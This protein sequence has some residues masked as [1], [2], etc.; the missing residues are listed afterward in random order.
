AIDDSVAGSIIDG[1]TR[2]IFP[3]TMETR[4]RSIRQYIRLAVM[5]NVTAYH[6]LQRARGRSFTRDEILQIKALELT[7]KKPWL[8][9]GAGT[10]VNPR[11]AQIVRLLNLPH[12][13]ALLDAD[14]TIISGGFDWYKNLRALWEL[15]QAR[16]FSYCA[17]V[18]DLIP[19]RCPHFVSPG[20]DKLLTDYFGEL[21][22]LADR[23]MCISQATRQEWLRHVHD[24][25]GEPAATSTFPLG[26]DL[27]FRI[28]DASVD[29]PAALNGKHF[30][31]YV[32][33][34]EP[35]KNHYMLYW[36]WE[37]CI[38]TKQLDP[39]RHRLV[40]V[41]RQGWAVGDLLHEIRTNPLTRDTI[42]ILHD[43]GDQQLAGL[44]RHCAFVLFPSMYEGFGLPLAEA[45]G[46]GK[47]C[48][49]SNAGALAEIGG[50]LVMRLDPK[51]TLAWSRMISRLMSSPV[52]LKSWGE[53]ISTTY[54]PIT[55]DAAARCFFGALCE[56]E[57]DTRHGSMAPTAS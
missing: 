11:K 47:P 50:D 36:A 5:R 35:R 42:L 4:K 54:R 18:Y 39:Q 27:S 22:W 15:K 38:R 12:G 55:W 16:G 41:G 3:E 57:C 20:Y 34:I 2:V 32:S 7:N 25:G 46:Y 45:L 53:R 49:A 40:L 9:P 19:V 26:S 48:L 51:D 44:Y 29:L 24:I 43:V 6:F 21:A 23:V 31:L 30:A 1:R 13:P 8:A 33:T 17:I 37:E 52:E 10:A 28:K 56:P 14:T